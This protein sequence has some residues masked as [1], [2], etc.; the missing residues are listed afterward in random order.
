MSNVTAIV[1]NYNDSQTVK[2]LIN[3]IGNY[4]MLSNIIIVDNCS[5]DNSFSDL[6]ELVSTKI[7]LIKTEYNGGYGYGNNRGIEYAIKNCPSNYYMICNPDIEFEENLILKMKDVLDENEKYVCA[8]AIPY[9]AD[10]SIQSGYA[11]KVPNAIN[12]VLETGKLLQKFFRF[13]KYPDDYCLKKGYTEVECVPGSLMLLKGKYL[14][15]LPYDERVFLYY[16]ETMLGY[17]FK[18][19]GLKTVIV[20]EKYIHYH[21][22]SI[23]KSISS[24][25]KQRRIMYESLMHY[26][27]YYL[28]INSLSF[29]IA[30]VYLMLVVY[31]NYF[32]GV[33][34]KIKNLKGNE[35]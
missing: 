17:K 32:D 26:L 30:R 9:K 28:K 11:W 8:S 18:K 2:R 24:T 27:K 7:T 35:I 4:E 1:L 5:T 6:K 20:N 22:V 14:F 19:Q 31:E 29:G 15:E 12:S 33:I 25:V 21:S 16:E 23:N 34:K 3:K 10:G 13:S